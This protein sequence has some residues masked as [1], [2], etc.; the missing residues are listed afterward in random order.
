[1][2]RRYTITGTPAVLKNSK[3]II[4]IGGKPRLIPSTKARKAKE[5][6]VAELKVQHTGEPVD[7]PIAVKFTFYG[8]WKIGAGNVPDLS[9]L[10][11]LPQ[12]AMQAA[13]VI[14]DDRL[15][16]SLDGTIRVCMCSTCE[17]R[18]KYVK[19]PKAGQYKPDCGSVKFCPFERTEIEITGY[20]EKS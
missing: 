18:L 13:G 8:A 17:H 12:D 6:A 10:L 4:N 20:S 3:Q 5:N 14:A 16:E 19:G 1:M 7:K 2:I 15:I 11:E 9:N